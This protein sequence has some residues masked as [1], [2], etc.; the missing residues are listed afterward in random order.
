MDFSR[1]FVSPE[2]PGVSLNLL[3]IA[4]FVS[5]PHYPRDPKKRRKKKVT[6]GNFQKQHSKKKKK[7]KNTLID[8]K[9]AKVGTSLFSRASYVF[10][11]QVELLLAR[12]CL[13]WKLSNI[14]T[15][16]HSSVLQTETSDCRWIESWCCIGHWCDELQNS[17]AGPHLIEIIQ[18]QFLPPGH[19][20]HE[21][22]LHHTPTYCPFMHKTHLHTVI[23]WV[24]S[25]IAFTLRFFQDKCLCSKNGYV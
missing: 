25:A 11:V 12:K 5:Q 9:W 20:K 15:A 22:L 14:Q 3:Q 23:L 1:A 19:K 13:C 6:G 24:T 2:I 16:I 17:A 8:N 21:Q 7:R 4:R 10:T 18:K